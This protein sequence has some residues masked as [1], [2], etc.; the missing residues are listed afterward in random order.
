VTYNI[1]TNEDEHTPSVSSN[2]TH[3]LVRREPVEIGEASGDQG[4]RN[5]EG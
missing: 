3:L 5:E 1:Q 4:R 2:M